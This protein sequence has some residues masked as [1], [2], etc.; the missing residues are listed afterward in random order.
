[1]LSDIYSHVEIKA[2]GPQGAAGPTGPMGATGPSGG[3]TGP[4]G[5]TGPAGYLSGTYTGSITAT[6]SIRG[7]AAGQTLN[8]I[9]LSN[10]ELNVVSTTTAT[11]RNYANFVTYS[12][13]PVSASSYLVVDFICA[14][15]MSGTAI[16]SWLSQINVDSTEIA[17]GTQSVN[18]TNDGSSGR[19]SGLFPLLG[20]YRNTDL[21]AKTIGIAAKR[22]SSDDHVI[23]SADASM[24][25]RIT[26]IA[27]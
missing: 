10:Q 9:V 27:R 23:I 17:Y 12:Y 18:N 14:Y 1:M 21:S 19:I 3:P 20:R 7:A 2:A 22:D 16:D 15:S 24:W 13:T 5:A 26:E 8:T 25:M 4:T 11:T 6:G